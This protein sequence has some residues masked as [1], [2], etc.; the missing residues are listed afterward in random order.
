MIDPAATRLQPRPESCSIA[1]GPCRRAVLEPCGHGAH[2]GHRERAGQIE[3]PMKEG[4]PRNLL[5]SL[6]KP[7]RRPEIPTKTPR[8]VRG[9]TFENP[10]GCG[11][12]LKG[13]TDRAPRRRRQSVS[14]SLDRGAARTAQAA[15]RAIP[16]AFSRDSSSIASSTASGVRS[17]Y[18][19]R[20]AKVGRLRSVRSA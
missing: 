17:G 5:A 13:Q 7:D 3:R 11:M 9:R 20:I 10:Q 8:V 19:L 12:A 6:P 18:S 2:E 1:R 14:G 4:D 16:S 15:V